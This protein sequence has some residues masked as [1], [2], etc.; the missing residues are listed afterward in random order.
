MKFLHLLNLKTQNLLI[1]KKKLQ[2]FKEY[3]I[4]KIVKN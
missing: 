2:K 1:E 3:Q 4:W